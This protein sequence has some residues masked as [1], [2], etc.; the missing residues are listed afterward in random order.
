MTYVLLSMV[1]LA[2]VSAVT[3]PTLRRLR[4]TPLLLTA[5]ALLALT[6]VFDNIIVGVGLVAY[7]DALISGVLMPVA[8][9]EDLAY[10]VAA[11]MI[12][13]TLWTWLARRDRRRAVERLPE[14]DAPDGRGQDDPTPASGME[15]GQKPS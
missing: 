5:A 8:P 4:L 11:V 2:L 10:A 9:V 14:S 13:P 6:V 3:V 1:V 12:V 7:D 15:D